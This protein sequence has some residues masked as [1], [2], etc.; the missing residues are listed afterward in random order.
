M[1]STRK[2]RRPALWII[3]DYT[4]CLE[5]HLFMLIVAFVML[6]PLL[7][8]AASSLKEPAQL[9]EY[10]PSCIPKPP[11]FSNFVDFRAD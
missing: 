5:K 8:M 11:V 6:S 10:P 4:R 7:W 2:K 3:E 1:I 9:F